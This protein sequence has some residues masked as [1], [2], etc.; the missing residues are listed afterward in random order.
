MIGRIWKGGDIRRRPVLIGRGL[1]GFFDPSFHSSS[2][3]LTGY[4][5]SCDAGVVMLVVALCSF[6]GPGDPAGCVRSTA[7]V[8]VW[9]HLSGSRVFV[10]T[11]CRQWRRSPLVE[12]ATRTPVSHHFPVATAR[13]KHLFPFRTEQLSPSA[14]MVLGSQGPGRV[15]RR[16]FLLIIGHRH[17]WGGR[18]GCP[19]RACVYLPRKGLRWG[20]GADDRPRWPIADPID[21]RSVSRPGSSWST[22]QSTS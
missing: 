12:D 18:G 8:C 20:C 14:P 2:G 11:I 13:G 15:G 17:T 16:R 21:L 5:R 6:E 22:S 9:V 19:L 10:E 7:H 3:T 4:L 1:D